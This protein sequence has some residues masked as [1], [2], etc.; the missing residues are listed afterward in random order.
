VLNVIVGSLTGTQLLQGLNVY[1]A[2]VKDLGG[3]DATST[4]IGKLTTVLL[5]NLS[6]F[7]NQAGH[8]LDDVIV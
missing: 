1:N 5:N 6:P 4:I 8:I 2:L 7:M 3:S